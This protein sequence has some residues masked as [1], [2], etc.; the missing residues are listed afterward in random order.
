MLSLTVLLALTAAAG[1]TEDTGRCWAVLS[2]GG[3]GL[4]AAWLGWRILAGNGPDAVEIPG[5][6][7]HGFLALPILIL[8]AHLLA[9]MLK[10]AGQH[11]MPW[12]D[13][14]TSLLIRLM[15]LALLVL[16]MQDVLT[17]VAHPRWMLTA[18]GLT[19]ALGAAGRLGASPAVPGAPALAL[20]GLAG[21]GVLLTPCFLPS[22][23][24][25]VLGG[26][27]LHEM[28]GRSARWQRADVMIRQSLAALLGGL[29]MAAHHRSAM[30]MAPA[31]LAAGGALLLSG[32]F[33]RRHR[34]VL[35]IIGLALVA[36]GSVGLWRSGWRPAIEAA[37]AFGTGSIPK[38]VPGQLPTG[39]E[40][41]YRSCGWL[42]AAAVIAGLVVALCWSL[43]QARSAAAGDQ[44]R[45]AL[46]AVVA[47]LSGCAVLMEGG[48]SLPSVVAVA[49][50]AWGL[51]PGMM[52]HPVHRSHGVFVTAAFFTALLVLGLDRLDRSPWLMTAI[53]G[54]EELA[55]AAGAF[56]LA[57]VLF[58]IMRCRGRTPRALLCAVMA[59]ALTAGGEYA[60]MILSN[61]RADWGDVKADCIGAAAGLAF[62]LILNALLRVENLLARRPRVS[63][64]KY[65][66]HAHLAGAHGQ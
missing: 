48:L 8:L 1:L 40:L 46:W 21:I 4:W 27:P 34:A 41:L 49:A 63:H 52:V 55:H 66:S 26:V 19:I 37:S 22:G 57:V 65:V 54:H 12:P 39:L 60:Q 42:G 18:L 15:L 62:M 36:G 58:W 30:A 51:M 23:P 56:L 38:L 11:Q 5:H 6:V 50:L 25:T 53:R 59:A 44:A 32:V 29:I 33:L 31:G 2:L 7:L 24:I 61:R 9:P 43:S 45:S 17:R 3:L 64:E 14:D 13:Q 47:A 20:S 35:A 16:L 10:H 28:Y